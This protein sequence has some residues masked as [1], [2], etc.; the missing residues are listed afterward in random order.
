MIHST[1]HFQEWI[2]CIYHLS[3]I[4]YDQYGTMKDGYTYYQDERR[5][6]VRATNRRY[7]S[8]ECCTLWASA[9]YA[10]VTISRVCSYPTLSV[11]IMQA[12]FNTMCCEQTFVWLSKFKK[13]MCAMPKEHFHFY[14]HRLIKRRNTY[15]EFC[16]SCKR[17][18]LLPKVNV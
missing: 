18:P 9:G 11:C 3:P 2:M 16:Y 8:R 5:P 14:M 6:L 17:R 4:R 7:V 12:S 13:I 10:I 15:I 1:L